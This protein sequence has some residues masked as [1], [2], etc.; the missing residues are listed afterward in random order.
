MSDPF[1]SLR[2]VAAPVD[3]D[4][5]FVDAVMQTV[6]ERLEPGSAGRSSTTRVAFTEMEVVPSN[7]QPTVR[8]RSNRWWVVAA[9]CVALVACGLTTVAVVREE[10]ARPAN[11]APP[12]SVGTPAPA[13]FSTDPPINWN[14]LAL[15]GQGSFPR[16]EPGSDIAT[17]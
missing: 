13:T 8:T 2:G 1:Q 15:E 14:D 3:P 9:A 17:G 11:D 4:D 10:G 16:V 12:A 5:E 7:P 6:R